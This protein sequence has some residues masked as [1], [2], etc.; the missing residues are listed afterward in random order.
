MISKKRAEEL[1]QQSAVEQK[2]LAEISLILAST[3]DYEETCCR[4]ADLA[5]RALADVC[6]VETLAESGEAR[7]TTACRG[8]VRRRWVRAFRQLPLN[9]KLPHLGSS[10]LETKQP[11]LINDVSTAYLASV[12]Q[13]DR[14]H[15]LL[16]DLAPQAILGLPLLAHGRLVG[17]L[18][19]LRT[20]AGRPFST[21]EVGLAEEVARRAALSAENARLYASAQHA[22]QLRD[23]VLSMVAHDLRNPLSAMLLQLKLLHRRG[24]QPERRSQGPIDAILRE[25]TRLNVL[26]Q[27]LLDVARFEAGKPSI[28]QQLISA[29]KVATSAVEGQKLL[30]SD[31]G[32]ALEL[33]SADSTAEVW[34]DAARLLQVFANLIGNAIKFTPP[35]GKITVSVEPRPHDVVFSVSDTGPGI[36]SEQIPH[37]FDRFWQASPTDRRG[38]GLG[39]SI[40]KAIVEAHG[41]H[42]WVE[43]ALGRGSTFR[44]AIPS[45]PEATAA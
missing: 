8:T 13:S 18:L 45:G 28:E 34:G 38:A 15:R 9:L 19:L 44:F 31:A 27:D 43:T 6:I 5:A 42:I 4:I 11:L 36:H 25:G 29:S 3:L 7:R 26:I 35:G 1:V 21:A 24:A 20:G 10:I 32:L 30:A 23:D 2:L 12:S 17:F 14:H 16:L 33:E 41:G 40:T 39:L 22:I 37:L